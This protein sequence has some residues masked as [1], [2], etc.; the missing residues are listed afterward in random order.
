MNNNPILK[1]KIFLYITEFVSG[2][3]VMGVETAAS[4]LLAPYFSSS[5]IVWT[6]IIGTIL[7]A[8][9]IGNILGGKMA[10]KHNNVTRLYVLLLI[11][12]A[13]ICIIPLFGRYV[14]ALV[15]AFFALFV[16]SN[17]LIWSSLLSCLILFVPPLLICGMVTPSLIK[18]TISND[19][20]NGSIVGRLEA[21]NTIGSIIGTFIP[22][23]ISI[24]TI[25]TNATFGLFGS[26]IVIISLIYLIVGF[27]NEI[28]ANK[29]LKENNDNEGTARKANLSNKVMACRILLLSS[30]SLI[31]I[32]GFIFSLKAKFVFWQDDTL[33]NEEESMYNYLQLKEDSQATYFSTN[34]M[35]GVQSMMKHDKSLT[36]MYYDY[37]LAAPYMAN[38]QNKDKTD[39]LIL[40][41]GT[42]T[43]ATLVDKY[44][45]SNKSITGIEID[46]KIIN[47]SYKYFQMPE[48]VEV[49]CDDGRAYLNRNTKKY[50]V[51]MVDAYSSISTPF[52]MSTIEFFRL[53]KSHLKDDGVMV[54]NINMIG[55]ESNTLDKALSD[56][57]F[58]SFNYI[59]KI[60]VAK[61][62]GDELFA[63]NNP[64]FIN[65]LN[66]SIDNITDSSIKNHMQYVS[67]NLNKYQ[68]SG[69]RLTDDNADVERRSIEAVDYI[70]QNELQFYRDI[71]HNKGFKGLL[72]Y[73]LG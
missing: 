13:Y 39:M 53:V 66:N 73:L 2:I 48:S 37:C 72:E 6:L 14:I 18:F 69:I 54:M 50:D 30:M 51:I 46:Q 15:S 12:G 61:G 52:Q 10:D 19:S 22:T 33:K 17:L 49:I 26:L 31:S 11:A 42:G 41:N 3:A 67:N 9:S 70:I 34:V 28:K 43:Y 25:G 59:Y 4:R 24:P 57:V 21:L 38:Y 60:P 65:N 35:F 71:Y 64:D 62:S 68:D 56:T 55:N 29:K 47:Y 7:I 44:I 45:P 20:N 8:M 58:D 1:K 23:F 5:Q 36:G 32:L 16:E 40:G 27:I 63:S